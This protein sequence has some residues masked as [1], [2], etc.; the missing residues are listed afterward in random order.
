[1][2]TPTNHEQGIS[3]TLFKMSYFNERFWPGW[4]WGT[5]WTTG[6]PLTKKIHL[7]IL[8][9]SPVWTLRFFPY[10]SFDLFLLQPVLR[11]RNYFLRFRLQFRFQL[12]KSYGSGSG[13]DYWKVTVPVPIPV[14]T[15]EKLRFRLRFWLGIQFIKSSIQQKLF[16]WYKILPF[17]VG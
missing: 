8:H 1:M 16:F 7:R 3:Q 4:K 10:G 12:L 5:R 9:S 6:W 2:K 14:P 13:S 11:D 17:D 15:I